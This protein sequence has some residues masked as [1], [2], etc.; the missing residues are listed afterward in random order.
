MDPRFPDL[1]EELAIGDP[2]EAHAFANDNKDEAR[3]ETADL[4]L[5]VLARLEIDATRL[6]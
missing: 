1:V 4:M 5:T 6:W 3:N 2:G